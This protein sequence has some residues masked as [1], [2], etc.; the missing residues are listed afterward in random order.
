MKKLG[1][2][3]C[4][5]QPLQ[6]RELGNFYDHR[7]LRLPIDN[8]ADDT[9]IAGWRVL[10]GAGPAIDGQTHVDDSREPL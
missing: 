1:H 3:P 8:E 2:K 4:R 5:L 7:F 9:I 6:S 10:A